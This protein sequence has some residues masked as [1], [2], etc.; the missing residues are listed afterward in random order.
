MK[1]HFFF[2]YFGNKR[3]EVETI[4]EGIDLDKYD[5][6]VEPYC[7]SCALSYYISTITTGKKYVLNDLDANL[8]K[9]LSL[10]PDEID[11]L[12][13]KIDAFSVDMTKEK[14]TDLMKEKTFFAYVYSNMYYKIRPGLYDIDRTKYDKKLKSCPIYNFLQNNDITLY[15]KD[16][17][18][19]IREYEGRKD[20]LLLLDPPYMECS[21]SYTNDYK[22]NDT[23]NIYNLVLTNQVY[24][25]YLLII[26]YNWVLSLVHVQPKKVYDK[27]YNTKSRKKCVH[28]IYSNIE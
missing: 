12:Q 14:Y 6:I 20:V 19:V 8:I 11:E 1:N 16:A 27:T 18:D 4:L 10:S 26:E 13:D 9:L 5:T 7:G 17:I 15:N 28:A 2:A 23:N 3:N 21:K 24:T 25:P 22:L